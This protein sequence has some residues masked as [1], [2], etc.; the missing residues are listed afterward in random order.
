MLGSLGPSDNKVRALVLP[1]LATTAVAH[2]SYDRADDLATVAADLAV[3]TEASLALGLLRDLA[4]VPPAG[5]R[6]AAVESLRGR[7]AAL[8]QSA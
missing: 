6:S 4:G 1:D 7:L 8:S 5:K 2:R 3:R